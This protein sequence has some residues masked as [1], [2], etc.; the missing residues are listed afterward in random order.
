VDDGETAVGGSPGDI[1]VQRGQDGSN[2]CKVLW[3]QVEDG[4]EVRPAEEG[5]ADEKI[6]DGV[7]EVEGREVKVVRGVREG[8]GVTV[9]REVGEVHVE[10]VGHGVKVVHVAKANDRLNNHDCVGRQHRDELE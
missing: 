6:L 1:V 8:H 2:F 4:V 10:R 5:E 3:E 7:A 9:V